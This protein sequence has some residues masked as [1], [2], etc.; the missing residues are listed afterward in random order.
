MT[1]WWF[2]AGAGVGYFLGALERLVRDI[3]RHGWHNDR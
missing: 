1:P 3:V 2:L